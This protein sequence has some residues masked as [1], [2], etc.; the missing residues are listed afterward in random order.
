MKAGILQQANHIRIIETR[1]PFPGFG[2]VRIKLNQVGIC[3]SDVHLFLGHRPIEKPTIIGHEGLGF[4]ETLGEGVD[5]LQVGERVVIEP[6]IPCQ[7]CRYCQKGKGQICPN[8]QVIGLNQSGCFAE[9]VCLPAAFVH[10]IPDSISDA[11][12]VLIEPLAVAYHALRIAGAKPGDSIAIIG[13]GAIG[14]LITHI[15]V[16]LGYRVFVTEK[17]ASKLAIA[18]KMGAQ[19][20]SSLHP[21]DIESSWL[22]E[23]IVSIFE[24]AGSSGTASLATQCAPR[25]SEIVL[26]GLSDELATFQPLKMTREGISIKPSLIYEHPTD[27]QKVIQLLENKVI[28]PSQIISGYFPLNRLQEALSLASQGLETKLIIDI[29]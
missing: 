21:E 4:I 14:L 7:K 22:Q 12:A 8:K 15:A 29:L 9:Y 3:G 16:V 26:L 10:E 11:D 24:C 5:Y 28:Q 13:L 6:N 23:E 27:F 17:H 1:L 25:G 19:V 18:K 2:E 20:I